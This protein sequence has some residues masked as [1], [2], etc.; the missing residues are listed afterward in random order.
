MGSLKFKIGLNNTIS[1]LSQTKL[2][3][4]KLP[5]QSKK[6]SGWSF[7][8]RLKVCCTCLAAVRFVK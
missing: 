5:Y 2:L 8:N 1:V 6:R 3:Q 4:T 7:K